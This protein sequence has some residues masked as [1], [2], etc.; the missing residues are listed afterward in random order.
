MSASR[1]TSA[2][3]SRARARSRSRSRSSARVERRHGR[4]LIGKVTRS[5]R[6]VRSSPKK[7][8]LDL[9]SPFSIFGIGV[10]VVL[11]SVV[12]ALFVDTRDLQQFFS[13]SFFSF[14]RYFFDIGFTLSLIFLTAGLVLTWNLVPQRRMFFVWVFMVIA[15]LQLLWSLSFF[16]L[17]AFVFALGVS[18]VLLFLF[19]LV[20]L[21]V[22][23]W[24]RLAWWFYLPYAAWLACSVTFTVLLALSSLPVGYAAV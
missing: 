22:L 20:F 17:H 21:S 10:I 7:Y 4:F 5:H 3:S 23:F 9:I 16:G 19:L 14:L 11:V 15:L 13:P 24:S 12:Q 6:S 18:L 2:R 8:V 1:R